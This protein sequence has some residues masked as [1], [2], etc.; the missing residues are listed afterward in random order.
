MN[1]MISEI[2]KKEINEYMKF[3]VSNSELPYLN[4]VYH[5][6]NI[7]RYQNNHDFWFGYWIGHFSAYL[8]SLA[9]CKHERDPDTSELDE[10][11]EIVESNSIHVQ[12][13]LDKKFDK[14]D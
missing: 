11:R 5:H 9:K 4:K 12:E 7:T 8:V 14:F 6:E 2:F 13:L 10:I 3:F 1:I